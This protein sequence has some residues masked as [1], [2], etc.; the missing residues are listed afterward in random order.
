MARHVLLTAS[1]CLLAL[2]AASC[3]DGDRADSQPKD[4]PAAPFTISEPFTHDNLTI[5]LLHGTDTLSGKP[6]MTWQEGLEQKKAVVHETKD[7]NQ[8]SV[9]NVSDDAE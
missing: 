2:A 8:L 6:L 3:A 4:N 7:V 1:L 5:F 9:E